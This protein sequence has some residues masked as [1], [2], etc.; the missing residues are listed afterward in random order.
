MK[1]VMFGHHVRF[2]DLKINL[3][4]PWNLIKKIYK[5]SKR[6][7][8]YHDLENSIINELFNI[9][10]F[11]IVTRFPSSCMCMYFVVDLH[12]PASSLFSSDYQS[13]G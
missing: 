1:K 12:D 10:F 6:T 3:T 11:K 7:L 4:S 2:I 13:V 8:M 9:S 5:E